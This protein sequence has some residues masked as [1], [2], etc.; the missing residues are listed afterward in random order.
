[1]LPIIES[2]VNP[3]KDISFYIIYILK[4]VI[5]LIIIGYIS[6]LIHKMNKC[7]SGYCS[8]LIDNY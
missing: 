7:I 4:F 8:A 6:Y 5:M 3:N 2:F 1:M